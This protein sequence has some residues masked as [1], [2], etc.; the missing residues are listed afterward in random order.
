MGWRFQRRVKLLPGVTMN[1]GKTG[2]SFSFGPRGA[3]VTVGKN[4]IR[5][6]VGIPGTGLSYST[7]DKFDNSK[8]AQKTVQNDSPAQNTLDV[9]FF[10]GLFMSE[11][12]KKLI[13]G[14]KAL[15]A[16]DIS[17]AK[18]H[19]RALPHIADAAFILAVLCLNLQDYNGCKSSLENVLDHIMD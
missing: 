14:I 11:D 5:K 10:S 17:T 15:L 3:K 12:E 6:T 4:G 9:G 19:L 16:N 8:N 13:S 18:Q 2:N 1:M 7:Y